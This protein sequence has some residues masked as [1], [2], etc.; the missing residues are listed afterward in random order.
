MIVIAIGKFELNYEVRHVFSYSNMQ[1]SW[2]SLFL[3]FSYCFE[4]F[5]PFVLFI[6]S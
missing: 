2:H 1:E 3:R 4:N 6:L 5:N